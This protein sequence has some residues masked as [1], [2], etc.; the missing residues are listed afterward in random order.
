MTPALDSSAL[1]AHLASQRWF[2]GKSRQI[3]DV[4]IFDR[5]EY[6]EAALMFLRVTYAGGEPDDYFAP[7]I[8]ENGSLKDALRSDAFCRSLLH[9]GELK[10]VRGKIRAEFT[11]LPSP[12]LAM[13]TTSAAGE[14][15]NS[16]V[17]FGDRFILKI[18]RLQHPGVNPEVEIGEHLAKREFHGV[19][20]HLGS[21]AYRSESGWQSSLAVLQQLVVNQGDGWVWMLRELHRDPAASP[22]AVT[23]EAA[24]TLGRR[25]AELHL[26]LSDDGGNPAFRPESLTVAGIEEMTARIRREAIETL[27]ML[28]DNLL[29]LPDDCQDM[30]Q[31][32]A[33]CGQEIQERLQLGADRDYGRRIRIH[34]D[35]HL[36]QVLRT[37]DDFVIVD[38]EGEPSRP[39]EQR[40]AKY[41]PL[42]D[43]AGMMRSFSYA[44]GATL[45]NDVDRR[46]WEKI[47]VE[48]FLASY[49]GNEA[50]RAMLPPDVE[51]IY[52]LL[53]VCELEKA[54]YELRYELNNRPAWIRIPLTAVA[55]FVGI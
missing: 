10:S 22:A 1:L 5:A 9:I 54:M 24:R 21:I 16:S 33:G 37:A 49:L 35:Y 34:G 55:G 26:A 29:R 53:E 39:M 12:S 45:R 17:I 46:L 7:L 19:P 30:A 48:E 8:A 11:S 23:I 31:R 3:R 25:T 52:R 13:P 40:R 14:Q 27:A 44:A 43:V 32:I 20:E 36:G 15:S 18:F 4:S 38:F 6:G 42:K 2:A 47:V 41:T 50:A 51:N 28:R